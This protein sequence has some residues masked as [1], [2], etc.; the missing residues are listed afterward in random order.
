MFTSL[1]LTTTLAAGQPPAPNYAPPATY[2]QPTTYVQGGQPVPMPMTGGAPVVQV[3]NGGVPVVQVPNTGVPATQTP[4]PYYPNG[5]TLNAGNPFL[6]EYIK[7][8]KEEPAPHKYLIERSLAETRLG[9]ILDN[10]GITIYGWTEMSYNASTNSTSN[11]PVFMIDQARQYQMNQ[12]YLVVEKTLDTSKDEF[13][14]GW[15]MN[16]I[17]PGTDARTTIP[18][19]LWFDQVTDGDP[20]PIDPFQFYA[21]AYLPSCKTTVKVGRFATHI[22]YELVQAPDTPFI[23]RSYMF[24]YNP[25]THTGLWA[26]TAL[27]D[28]WTV[29]YGASTGN[30]TFIDAATNRLTFLGQLKW[31]PAEGQTSVSLNCTVT[32]PTY[33]AAAQFQVYNNYN[34]V[35]IH[36]FNDKLSYVLDAGYSHMDDYEDI[37]SVNWYGAANYLIYNHSDKCVSTLR[38]EVFEDSQGA[39]TGSKGLYTEVTYGVAVKPLPGVIIRPSARY[40]NNSQTGAFDGNQNLFTGAIDLIFRW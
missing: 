28:T 5:S 20:Y 31:A 40:D 11:A 35:V 30:D 9:E 21:Q 18:R 29:G 7:D 13:Q 37:G 23:S 19:G 2:R 32:N 6:N 38:A 22:G 16:W 8:E 39:R 17:L 27:N 1:L 25:F 36:A 4:L 15:A 10:R 12:N 34:V 24:Q 3:P 26:T 33:I 14:W